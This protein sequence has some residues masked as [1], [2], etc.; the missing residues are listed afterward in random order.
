[1]KAKWQP[2]L[3]PRGTIRSSRPSYF[4]PTLNSP[5]T[6]LKAMT[7]ENMS[8]VYYEF[9]YELELRSFSIVEKN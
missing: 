7:G 9:F 5:L 2:Y 4:G 3:D 6:P 8:G 1:V